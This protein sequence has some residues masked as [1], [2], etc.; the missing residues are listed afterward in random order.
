MENRDYKNYLRKC[1]FWVPIILYRMCFFAS[2]KVKTFPDSTG[3]IKY[4]FGNL[5]HGQLNGRTPIYPFVIRLFM[6]IVGETY[7][8]EAV[9]IFQS[10]VSFIAVVFFFRICKLFSLNKQ[11]TLILTYLYGLNTSIIGWD[12]AILTESLALSLL[13][14]TFFYTFKF[15][16]DCSARSAIIAVILVFVMIFERPSSII[17]YLMIS[18]FIIIFCLINKIKNSNLIYGVML[19]TCAVML[20]Y[21]TAFYHQY[22]VFSLTDAVPRQHLYVTI[23][24]GY[25]TSSSDQKFIEN[26]DMALRAHP[27]DKWATMV[28]VL[29]K[30]GNK[31]VTRLTNE[32]YRKNMRA[33]IFD[34]IHQIYKDSSHDYI[35]DYLA[36]KDYDDCLPIKAMVYFNEL[37]RINVKHTIIMF[38]IIIAL[39]F[40]DLINKRIKWICLGLFGSMFA[41]L[42][43]S[44]YG[45]CG[46][47]P[48]TMVCLIPIFYVALVYILN[49]TCSLNGIKDV[50]NFEHVGL[51]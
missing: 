49:N 12:R 24:H 4:Q 38:F 11:L 47:Y 36:Y 1:A 19:A 29:N 45:T 33:F 43:V 35:I 8:L 20:I 6:K 2:T 9:T 32:C 26:V 46:E 31:E 13:M 42:F 17:Y 16:K 3:Y 23:D 51:R 28:E 15:I 48:R 22:G 5:L 7:Y 14:I 40:K 34:R 18:V 21:M 30:Y 27:D 37:F 50:I 41:T 25:Y 39:F 44:Y 10:I